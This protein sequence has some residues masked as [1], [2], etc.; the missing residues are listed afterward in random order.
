MLG[1]IL[2]NEIEKKLTGYVPISDFKNLAARLSRLEEENSRLREGVVDFKKEVF[3]V[4]ELADVLLLDPA[5]VR[6][7]YI[8]TGKIAATKPGKHWE[9]RREEYMRVLDVVN[10][11]G[12]SYL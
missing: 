3:S 7:N 11:R 5:T 9:I 1:Q 2:E 12:T 4:K 10:T 6:K 8:S